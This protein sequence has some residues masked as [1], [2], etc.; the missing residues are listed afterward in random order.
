M[1]TIAVIGGTGYVGAAV[2]EEAARRGHAVTAVSR[3]APVA[4]VDG[5]R[6]IQGQADQVLPGAVESADVVV[7]ALSPR[8]ENAGT[9]TRVY[10]EL[11]DLAGPETR[12][13]VVG[14]F[15]SLRPAPGAARFADG[16]GMP[17]HVIGEARE[18]LAVLHALED[19]PESLDWLFI[20]PAQLFGAHR[21]PR[22]ARGAYRV[23]DDVALFEADGTSTIEVADF[24]LAVLDEIERP[25]HHRT[26]IGFVY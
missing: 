2:V 18:M 24:A 12:V 14:G 23:S 11:A 19:A 21:A 6:Y 1:T 26:Q 13:I 9:L 25:A 15:G 17:P 22:P 10:G 16:E 5:V 7:A 20:S 3:S 8:G 4:P